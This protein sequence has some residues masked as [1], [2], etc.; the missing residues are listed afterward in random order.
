MLENAPSNKQLPLN[1]EPDMPQYP[2]QMLCTD[3]MEWHGHQYLIIVDKYSNWVSILK[4]ARNDSK[5]LIQA[6]RV[7]FATFGVA[8]TEVMVLAFIP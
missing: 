6:F 5:N 4:L 2:F 7:Y 8:E 1:P 3:M